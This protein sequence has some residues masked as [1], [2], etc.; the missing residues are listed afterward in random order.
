MSLMVGFWG[1]SFAALSRHDERVVCLAVG[2]ILVI[3]GAS[4]LI[5]GEHARMSPRE[6]SPRWTGAA[7]ALVGALFA[8]VGLLT[9]GACNHCGNA[10]WFL[11]PWL[12]WV[13]AI[14]IVSLWRIW[15]NPTDK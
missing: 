9:P 6:K 4:V 8:A 14:L 1:L 12:V 7:T 15:R 5:R 3:I 11:V 10:D 2:T 13:G